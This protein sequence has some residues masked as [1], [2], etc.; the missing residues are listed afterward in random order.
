MSHSIHKKNDLTTEEINDYIH[1]IRPIK[2]TVSIIGEAAEE[3]KKELENKDL[4][5]TLEHKQT[6]NDAE[7]AELIKAIRKEEQKRKNKGGK[8]QTKKR[9]QLKRKTLKKIK[10]SRK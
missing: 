9:K 7:I 10:Y 2:G 4:I 8:K 6:L 5:K 3:I 1:N